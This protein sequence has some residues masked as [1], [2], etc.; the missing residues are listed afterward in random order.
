MSSD[1]LNISS[2]EE[3]DNISNP[4]KKFISENFNNLE[5]IQNMN[6]TVENPMNNTENP[7]NN[8]VENNNL[9]SFQNQEYINTNNDL[10]LNPIDYNSSPA[11][12]QVGGSSTNTEESSSENDSQTNNFL[13][14]SRGEV[15]KLVDNIKKYLIVQIQDA[16]FNI[17]KNSLDKRYGV[18]EMDDSG[19]LALTLIQ[20]KASDIEELILLA[21]L[22]LSKD[23]VTYEN[24]ED[25]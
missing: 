14:L 15:V 2:L 25:N 19:N 23:D 1:I 8:T 20:I 3:F 24:E 10:E 16:F 13:E 18:R 17:N 6:N 12:S 9:E 21:T 22:K 7:M 11:P 5:N 4:P